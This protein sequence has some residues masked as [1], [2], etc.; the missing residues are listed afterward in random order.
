MN[1][2]EIIYLRQTL[3]L[4]DSSILNL[5]D[6]SSSSNNDLL[7][8]MMMGGMQGGQMG[9]MNPLMLSLLLGD[10]VPKDYSAYKKICDAAA[11]PEIA[12]CTA[13][14]EK[15]YDAANNN[16]KKTGVSDADVKKAHDAIMAYDKSSSSSP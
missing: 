10:D 2:S 6:S 7:M 3:K 8:L 12:T 16:A 5:D 9:G 13:E 4:N 15:I 1:L 14:I 11:A